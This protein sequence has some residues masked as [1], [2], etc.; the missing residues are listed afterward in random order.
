MAGVIDLVADSCRSELPLL[1]RRRGLMTGLS[2]LLDAD[3][4]VWSQMSVDPE[5]GEHTPVDMVHNFPERTLRLLMSGINDPENPCPAASKLF[6]MLAAN[7]HQTRRRCDLV[8]D[9]R[10]YGST[11]YKAYRKT[12]GIDDC[13]YSFYVGPMPTQSD[14][15]G[16]GAPVG[17]GGHPRRLISG[18]V[19]HRKTER[20]AFDES[21]A[22]LLH[23]VLNRVVWLHEPAAAV[24]A[25]QVVGELTTR[26]RE[27]VGYLSEGKTVSQIAGVMG[28]SV[29][30]VNSHLKAVHKAYGVTNRSQLL[31]RLFGG[32]P[33]DQ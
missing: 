13:I 17:H 9:R 4:W 3:Y 14:P 11:H 28:V 26:Q 30:T 5:T 7:P 32:R 10:W 18:V 33:V 12:C 24:D 21:R 22:R 15:P 6:T 25:Q 23:V 2:D 20:Q 27:V 8:T 31:S 29:N 16:A 1:E 19:L